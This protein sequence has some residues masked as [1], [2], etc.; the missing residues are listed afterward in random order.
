MAAPEFESA[1]MVMG[2]KLKEKDAQDFIKHI[3]E[4]TKNYP[5]PSVTVTAH[6]PSG[7]LPCA[8]RTHE[9]MADVVIC[10]LTADLLELWKVSDSY[11]LY[12]Y[13]HPIGT[14]LMTFIV[15]NPGALFTLRNLSEPKKAELHQVCDL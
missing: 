15:Q 6:A 3:E 7:S 8:V 1:F 9:E 12:S 13:H 14:E 5:L 11:E 10:Y 2:A 4:V